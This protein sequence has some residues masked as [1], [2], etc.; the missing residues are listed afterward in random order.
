MKWAGCL[1][2]SFLALVVAHGSARADAPED[3]DSKNPYA[4]LDPDGVP[5]AVTQGSKQKNYTP[6]EIEAMRQEAIQAARNRNW[7]M[8]EYEEQLRLH[9]KD[10]ADKDKTP[11]L[12]LQLSMDKN[13]AQLAGLD[14]IE[15]TTDSTPAP[16]L[17]ATPA[18]SSQNAPTLRA[19][20]P[21]S[22][23]F[24]PLLSTLSPSYSSAIQAFSISTYSPSVPSVLAPS[25]LGDG[26]QANPT[27]VPASAP[28]SQ[29]YMEVMDIQ[30]P[31][32]VAAKDNSLG[33]TPTPDLNLDSLPGDNL[34]G[35]TPEQAEAREQAA[36]RAEL[37][38]AMDADKLHEEE[39]AKL[40]VPTMALQGKPSS[41]DQP[42]QPAPPKAIPVN[43][44][45]APIPVTQQQQLAP[46]H[47]PIAN[48]FDIL[49]R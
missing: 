42:Q 23:G 26:P 31:G 44:E 30:T 19:D 21:G 22:R 1:S 9:S 4:Q 39:T 15:A 37:P 3:S 11:N 34:P 47:A 49:N 35:E 18:A 5:L 14:P 20:P 10:N 16:E 43:P 6:A 28:H 7:L 29:S 45:D 13:L 17:H 46:V 38:Q 36:T 25:P 24:T 40:T 8:N 27:P 41:S 32:M 33:D 12:Y 2:V 48:P